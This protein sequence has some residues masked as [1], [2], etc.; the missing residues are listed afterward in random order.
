VMDGATTYLRF[1]VVDDEGNAL[2]YPDS[3]E[4]L[5]IF[6]YAS[7]APLEVTLDISTID[8]LPPGR[9]P[10]ETRVVTPADYEETYAF[11]RARLELRGQPLCGCPPLTAAF[12]DGA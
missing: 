7:D 10:I 12:V 3:E 4:L 2:T 8:E 6:E 9:T 1:G 5:P 11:V